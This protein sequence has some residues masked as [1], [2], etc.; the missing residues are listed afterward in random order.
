MWDCER[1]KDH[2][3]YFL[4]FPCCVTKWIRFSMVYFLVIKIEVKKTYILC[5][6]AYQRSIKGYLCS[7]QLLYY[8]KQNTIIRC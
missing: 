5:K 4:G 8:S 3:R 1:M 7:D 2:D 6:T